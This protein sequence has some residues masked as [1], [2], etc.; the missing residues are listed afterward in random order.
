MITE[1]NVRYINFLNVLSMRYVRRCDQLKL[2]KSVE[3]SPFN[4]L[5][6]KRVGAETICD[7][8]QANEDSCI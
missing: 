5:M 8:R 6:S 7:G 2:R 1:R 4:F 3:F